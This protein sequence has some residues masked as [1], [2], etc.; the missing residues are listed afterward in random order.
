MQV[1]AGCPMHGQGLAW[2]PETPQS[3]I[4]HRLS[5]VRS[6]RKIKQP[7]G[8]ESLL[9]NNFCEKTHK[10]CCFY[11]FPAYSAKK[12]SYQALKFRG[13]GTTEPFNCFLKGG[14]NSSIGR[15][16]GFNRKAE[17]CISFSFLG[18]SRICFMRSVL[19]GLMGV[20]QSGWFVQACGGGQ[21][22]SVQLLGS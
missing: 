6:M 21:G 12:I 18:S 2:P 5:C 10:K 7:L 17:Y 3:L 11:C 20:D 9:I 15:S 22:L 13:L 1:I 14:K 16:F 4:Y 19:F 8:P